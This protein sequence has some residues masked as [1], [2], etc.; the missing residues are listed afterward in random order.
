MHFVI[1][2]LTYINSNLLKLNWTESHCQTATSPADQYVGHG[3]P[4]HGAVAAESEAWLAVDVLRVANVRAVV[5]L[6]D[7][8]VYPCSFR[9]RLHSE[10]KCEAIKRV[11]HLQRYECCQSL[12]GPKGFCSM[13]T[14]FTV[15]VFRNN[16]KS[17]TATLSRRIK[18]LRRCE[19]SYTR[20][21]KPRTRFGNGLHY[22]QFYQI[23][24]LNA[25]QLF[26][27]H[28]NKTKCT[29]QVTTAERFS[30]VLNFFQSHSNWFQMKKDQTN[31]GPLSIMLK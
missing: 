15:K 25:K 30:T 4:L 17:F 21:S 26:Q 8:H 24:I 22:N 10:G 29:L 7:G 18:K 28:K 23:M 19:L 5:A 12:D 31:V 13:L 14:W 16:L 1:F 9:V 6:V 20:V 27:W 3:R 2:C 11:F